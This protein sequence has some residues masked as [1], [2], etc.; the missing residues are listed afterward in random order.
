MLF[1]YGILFSF[2]RECVP[3]DL[4]MVYAREFVPFARVCMSFCIAGFQLVLQAC[5]AFFDLYNTYI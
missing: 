2:S 5:L 4:T 1:V 3:V